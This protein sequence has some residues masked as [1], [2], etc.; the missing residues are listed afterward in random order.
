MCPARRTRE[1]GIRMALGAGRPRIVRLVLKDGFRPIAE[2]LFIGLA[3][4]TVIRVYLKGAL[5]NDE[6]VPLDPVACVAAAVLV[7]A[8]GA[9][10][11]Y[12]PARRAAAVDPNVALRNL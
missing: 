6:V 5:R 10:A 11:C 2:G 12:L 4:A 3:T 9:L 7:S 1:M 8:A